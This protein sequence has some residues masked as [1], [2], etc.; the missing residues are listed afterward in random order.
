MQRVFKVTPS[1]TT[2]HKVMKNE[3]FL[4]HSVA[5]GDQV[6]FENQL[7][8]RKNRRMKMRGK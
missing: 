8:T 6:I 3:C 4:K 7:L 1:E 2:S 5:A